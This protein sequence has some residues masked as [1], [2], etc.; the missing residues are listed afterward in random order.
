MKFSVARWQI[1][2]YCGRQKSMFYTFLCSK[3]AP[4]RIR[5]SQRNI[6][7]KHF[8]FC[9]NELHVL[10]R[11]N[12]YP[13]WS[14]CQFQLLFVQLLFTLRSR[15]LQQFCRLGLLCTWHTFIKLLYS[16]PVLDELLLNHLVVFTCWLR[17]AISHWYV[18]DWS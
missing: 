8:Q 3:R 1:N 17:V 4:L 12:K 15:L 18:V 9:F 7:V 2:I 5:S 16:D 14:E 10:L 13:A 11:T 6:R